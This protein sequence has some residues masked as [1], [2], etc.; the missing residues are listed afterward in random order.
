MERLFLGQ[1]LIHLAQKLVVLVGQFGLALTKTGDAL[2]QVLKGGLA[3]PPDFIGSKG[4]K[5]RPCRRV[6]VI[7]FRSQKPF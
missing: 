2:D 3:H 7:R 5:K 6:S 1:Q 4:R